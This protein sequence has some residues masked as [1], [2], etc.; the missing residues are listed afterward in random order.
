MARLLA[1]AVDGRSRMVNSGYA[2]VKGGLNGATLEFVRISAE[3]GYFCD[4]NGMLEG[5]PLNVAASIFAG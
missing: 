3:L 5:Q 4:D 1:L 2:G